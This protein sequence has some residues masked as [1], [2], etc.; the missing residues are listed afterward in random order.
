L[1]K[2]NNHIFNDECFGLSTEYPDE[3][4]VLEYEGYEKEI[5]APCSIFCDFEAIQ[6]QVNSSNIKIDI[7]KFSLN[8]SSSNMSNLIVF[9][10]RIVF[11]LIG[12]KTLRLQ[13]IFRFFRQELLQNFI[14]TLLY[15]KLLFI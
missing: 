3:G 1:E 13:M 14:G 11:G 9:I 4:S 12:L 2:L 7:E 6:T 5:L 10:Y 8:D 15:I